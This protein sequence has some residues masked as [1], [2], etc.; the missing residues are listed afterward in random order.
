MKILHL[1]DHLGLGGAQSL[2][3]DIFNNQISNE[4]IFL[5]ALRSK[6]IETEIKHRNVYNNSSTQI[7]SF[8]PLIFLRKL[9]I[10]ENIDI[11][12]CHLMGSEYTGYLL[13]KLFFPEIVLIFH[14]HGK[15]LSGAKYYPKVLKLISEK[16]DLIIAI[17]KSTKLGLT[18]KAG[19]DDDKIRMIYNFIDTEK[20][21][22]INISWD[23]NKEK[24]KLNLDPNDFIVGFAGRIV[25]MKGWRE[26]ILSSKILTTNYS[27]F[28]FIIAGDG[29]DKDNLLDLINQLNLQNHVQYIGFQSNMKKFYS[30][31]DCIVV[32]SHYEPMGLTPIEA[33]AMGVPVIVSNV[34]ALNEIIHHGEDALFFEVKNSYDL[35]KKILMIY[36]DKILRAKL[37]RNGLVNSKLYS[38]TKYFREL[39]HTYQKTLDNHNSLLDE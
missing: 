10:R 29:N 3:A 26:F 12:H 14:E 23:I 30:M 39:D 6:T 21:N 1:I 20:F 13:K 2:V 7:F 36:N 22:K 18:T 31:L 19:I 27:N 34:P 28:Q 4:N 25:G 32:P 11:I 37:I 35:S 15:I 9:I 24:N 5:C 33:Q 8:K 38:M 16:I 17:S